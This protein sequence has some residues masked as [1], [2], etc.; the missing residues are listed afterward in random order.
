[1]KNKLIAIIV[2]VAVIGFAFITCDTGGGSGGNNNNN[3]NNNGDGTQGGGGGGGGSADSALNGTWKNDGNN[4]VVTYNN[5]SYSV[6]DPD[7]VE[8]IR[9]TY[10]TSGDTITN[11]VTSYYM[12]ADMAAMY[13]TSPGWKNRS[14]YMDLYKAYT[15]NNYPNFTQAQKDQANA[16]A[17][18]MFTGITVK[19]SVTG[20]TLWMST[21]N[22]TDA[23]GGTSYYTRIS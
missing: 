6:R 12:G 15:N 5:G 22:G 4:S 16:A 14:Q 21:K 2:L 20:N 9:G 7:G 10:T 18:E 19:Y 3:N 17:E 8:T 13:N 11:K 1:M 23:I